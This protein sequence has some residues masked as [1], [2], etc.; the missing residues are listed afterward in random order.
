MEPTT[1]YA[2]NLRR[3]HKT[4]YAIIWNVG[5]SCSEKGRKKEKRRDKCSEKGKRETWMRLTR[6]P[7]AKKRR[8]NGT[9]TAAAAIAMHS[10]TQ[11]FANV[12][13]LVIQIWFENWEQR[14]RGERN[15]TGFW[16]REKKHGT[17]WFPFSLFWFQR[18]V[19]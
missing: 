6:R 12:L 7:E 2:F 9:T 18:R 1:V 19:K 5:N 16:L 8:P 10:T 14:K 4:V 3:V 17:W 13:D 15:G 11:W